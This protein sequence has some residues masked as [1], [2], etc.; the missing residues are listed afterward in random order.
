MES[1]ARAEAVRGPSGQPIP[2]FAIV[3]LARRCFASE[4]RGGVDPVAA[5]LPDETPWLLRR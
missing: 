3:A 1:L 4:D 5:S 2:N